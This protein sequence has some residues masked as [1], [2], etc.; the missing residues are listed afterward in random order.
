MRQPAS[1]SQ[2]SAGRIRRS[3]GPH[4]RSVWEDKRARWLEIDAR[5]EADS[6]GRKRVEHLGQSLRDE[7][8]TSVRADQIRPAA[9]S[10]RRSPRPDGEMRARRTSD[11]SYA[12]EAGDADKITLPFKEETP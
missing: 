5:L 11:L 3:W 7:R 4:R 10:H 2:P 6:N 1:P 9:H 8:P 12:I